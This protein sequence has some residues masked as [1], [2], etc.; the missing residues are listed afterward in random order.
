MPRFLDRVV[1]PVATEEDARPTAA[2][3]RPGLVPRVIEDLD[4]TVVM[5][6]AALERGL[7][8]RPLGA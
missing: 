1:V 2:L 7:M 5:P 4:A 3:A 6:E 8:E